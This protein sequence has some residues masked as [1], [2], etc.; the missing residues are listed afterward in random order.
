MKK[1]RIRN[2]WLTCEIEAKNQEKAEELVTKAL[3]N[4]DFEVS[5]EELEQ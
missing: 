4:G 5:V 1:W 2:V 3:L